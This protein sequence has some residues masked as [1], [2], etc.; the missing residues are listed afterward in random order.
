M[1]LNDEVWIV[2]DFSSLRLGRGRR[3]REGARAAAAGNPGSARTT[4]SACRP[5]SPRA[6]S[7]S[8]SSGRKCRQ[9]RTR[10]TISSRKSKDD[11]QA[12]YDGEGKAIEDEY[13]QKL[14]TLKQAIADRAASLKL[15]YAPDPNFPSPEVWA[16]AYRLGLYEVPPGVDTVKE[17]KWLADQ[18]KQ[19]R[20]FEKSLDDPQR[21]TARK[22]G[23]TEARARAEARRPQRQDRRPGPAHRR[24]PGGRGTAEGGTGAGPGRPCRRPVSR[25][26]VWTTSIMA[27]SYSPPERKTFPT[28]FPS[29]RMAVSPGCPTIPSAR[30]RAGIFIGSSPAPP[31]PTGR[32]YWA[33]QQVPH[34]EEQDDGK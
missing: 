11:A 29:S 12:L 14:A 7:A 33:L 16:N 26:D 4:C 1:S 6:R 3:S 27:S 19:W 17:H 23:T 31:G 34:G 22:G 28:T 24:H 18:M 15:Q 30:A 8:G 32:Q 20:D 21:T 9:R 5:T 2:S 13:N 25:G 10:S